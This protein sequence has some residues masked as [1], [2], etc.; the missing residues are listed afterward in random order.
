MRAGYIVQGFF[1]AW[2]SDL[3]FEESKIDFVIPRGRNGVNIKK[4][5]KVPRAKGCASGTRSGTAATR[6]MGP[7]QSMLDVSGPG[8][9]PP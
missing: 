2:C 6:F 3:E 7:F 1:Q 5:K 9:V 4:V 8:Y